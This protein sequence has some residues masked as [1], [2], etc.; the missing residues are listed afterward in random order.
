MTE[1]LLSM[2]VVPHSLLSWV[3]A[4][5]KKMKDGDNHEIE[6][7]GHTGTHLLLNK[8]K[9]DIYSGYVHKEDRKSVV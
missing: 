3:V 1:Q 4:V 5:T 8:T 6:V 2:M 9:N 7:P